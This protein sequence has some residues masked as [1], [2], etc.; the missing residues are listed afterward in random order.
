MPMKKV[1]I[2]D[3]EKLSR[4]YF[5]NIIDWSE[6]GFSCVHTAADGLEVYDKVLE[7]RYDLILTDI[8]MPGINGLDLIK[9]IQQIPHNP[10]FIIMSGYSEFEYA[11]TAMR[12]GV[13]Y[14]LLKP[15]EENELRQ[16]L[17]E[18]AGRPKVHYSKLVSSALSII[19]ENISNEGLSLKW[20]ASDKLFMSMD[21][22]GR[23][24]R[25]EVGMPF[26]KY[27]IKERVEM[28]KS[29][30]SSDPNIK[31]YDVAQ[32]VGFGHNSQYFCDVF[33]KYTSL[34]PKKFQRRNVKD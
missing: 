12:L 29:L 33:K 28:A 10:L 5:V 6:Y 30:L 17:D 15:V 4:D 3:D 18:L 32:K 19:E 2:V 16:I 11:Q 1:L 13:K 23:L 7:N 8:R 26:S 25:K 9:K 34:T 24:F 22:L 14:Y 31:V 21:Y 27:V 20:L